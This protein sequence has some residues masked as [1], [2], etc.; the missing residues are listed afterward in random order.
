MRVK[1]LVLNALS[2]FASCKNINSSVVGQSVKIS[3]YICLYIYK[4]GQT[5]SR[6]TSNSKIGFLVKSF[7]VNFS[8]F[9]V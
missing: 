8:K 4:P 5:L 6:N 3:F 9:P 7:R 1:T 2:Y